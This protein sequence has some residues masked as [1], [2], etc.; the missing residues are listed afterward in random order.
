MLIIGYQAEGTLGRQLY[1]R[2]KKVQVMQEM[3]DVRAEVTSIGAY[4]AHADQNMLT[5]WVRAAAGKPEQIFCTHGE[6]GAAAA[7]ATRLSSELQTKA[8]VPRLLDVVKL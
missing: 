8:S 7:L 6:E 2:H 5:N 1:E 4:S 3:I